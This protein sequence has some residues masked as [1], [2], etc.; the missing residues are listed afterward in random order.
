M[1]I[2]F[3]VSRFFKCSVK[4]VQ[5][6][7]DLN[8]IRFQ[9]K[10]QLAVKNIYLYQTTFYCEFSSFFKLVS[11]HWRA[12]A[13]IKALASGVGRKVHE[14]QKVP[15]VI[16]QP[17]VNKRIKTRAKGLNGIR[18]KDYSYQLLIYSFCYYRLDITTNF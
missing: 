6:F 11:V 18:Y 16:N 17:N 1:G 12:D 13:F 7:Y 2:L 8:K 5:K 4:T 10:F 15:N 14:D 3:P 9:I